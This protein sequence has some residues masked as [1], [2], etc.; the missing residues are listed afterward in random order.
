MEI[1]RVLIANRGEIA[2]RIA[3]TCKKMGIEAVT[4]FTKHDEGAL[5]CVLSSASYCISSYSDPNEYI[6]IAKLTDSQAVH[7]GYGFLAENVEFAD[8]CASQGIKF[9]GPSSTSLQLFGCKRS[10]KELAISANVPTLPGSGILKNTDEALQAA[11]KIGYPVL[12]KPVFGG[13]GIGI[14][15]CHNDNDVGY[16]VKYTVF[17][18]LFIDVFA[19][20]VVSL[21]VCL[22][23]CMFVCLVY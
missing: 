21:F 3:R 19:R 2:I 10:T 15:E 11:K 20:L 13:G 8:I 4:V 6:R 12:V 18:C 14:Q 17:F 9:I 23:P 16:V 5:H 22:F 1:K 7:P